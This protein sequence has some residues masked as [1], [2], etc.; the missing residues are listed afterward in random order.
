MNILGKKR[1]SL[2]VWLHPEDVSHLQQYFGDKFTPC[3]NSAQF[4]NSVSKNQ[5]AIFSGREPF[6]IKN[7][8]E[9]VVCLDVV[10]DYFHRYLDLLNYQ[11]EN[12]KIKI[13]MNSKLWLDRHRHRESYQSVLENC[14]DNFYFCDPCTDF[15]NIL[16][17]IGKDN[18]KKQLGL[19]LD[20]K[21][22]FVSLRRADPHLTIFE[23]NESFYK[24]AIEGIKHLKQ[25]GYCI[26][27]RRRRGVDD[28]NTRRVN[29]PVHTKYD[30]FKELIIRDLNGL[31]PIIIH[32]KELVL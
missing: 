22:A 16:H 9:K 1:K 28:L 12:M 19:P 11:K 7:L 24:S 5:V 21:I 15:K 18:I 3:Y 32:F 14:R 30:S 27:S 26:I 2:E 25:Q 23:T 10:G 4:K 8:C 17:N 29:S 31:K 6:I 20:K 13:V